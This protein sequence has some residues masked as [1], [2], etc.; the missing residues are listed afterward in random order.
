MTKEEYQNSEQYQN[1][2]AQIKKAIEDKIKIQNNGALSSKEKA[3]K[4]ACLSK[5]LMKGMRRLKLYIRTDYI[6]EFRSGTEATINPEDPRVKVSIEKDKENDY[7]IIYANSC[8]PFNPQIYFMPDVRTKFQFLKESYIT[9]D[10]YD[11]KKCP[12]RGGHDLADYYSTWKKIIEA[13]EASGTKG[14]FI[15]LIKTLDEKI[16]GIS[17]DAKTDNEAMDKAME[18]ICF[19]EINLFPGLSLNGQWAS[20]GDGIKKWLE[21]NGEIFR[22]LFSR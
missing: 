1:Y 9:K 7:T 17:D 11:D 21:F 19:F 5:N 2:L 16:D 22:Y 4:I 8:G 14:F 15:D 18:S 10:R 13:G 6:D 20:N 3:E 12:D